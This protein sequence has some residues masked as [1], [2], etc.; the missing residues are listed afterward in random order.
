M[1]GTGFTE[2]FVPRRVIIVCADKPAADLDFIRRQQVDHAVSLE[3]RS[4]QD[5]D[6]QDSSELTDD[7]LRAAITSRIDLIE[8]DVN[9]PR[10]IKGLSDWFDAKVPWGS[11]AQRHATTPSGPKATDD[12]T[13]VI[14]DSIQSFLAWAGMRC[15]AAMRPRLIQSIRSYCDKR[16]LRLILVSDR[17]LDR[18]RNDLSHTLRAASDSWLTLEPKTFP[19]VDCRVRKLPA[20]ST[21]GTRGLAWFKPETSD[22]RPVF[23]EAD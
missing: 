2:L 23:V 11:G 1:S 22:Y 7:Q 5:S 14:I 16:S 3:R 8:L 21:P 9:S 19:H 15:K 20:Y 12:D 18:S 13:V 4:I 17:P 6:P 10:S